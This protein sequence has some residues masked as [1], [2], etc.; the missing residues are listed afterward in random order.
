MTSTEKHKLFSVLRTITS[1]L[2]CI[3][4][5]KRVQKVIGLISGDDST[6]EFSFL[7]NLGTTD[8]DVEVYDTSDNSTIGVD[9]NRSS[10]NEVIITFESSPP[11]TGE[12]FR[13]V[14]IG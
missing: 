4:N 5:E 1:Q 8:V 7:H 10:E 14:I 13:V 9:V 3:Y 2:K 6:S 12:N 11:A